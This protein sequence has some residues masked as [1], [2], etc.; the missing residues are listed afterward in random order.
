MT[1]DI[2]LRSYAGDIAW[3]PWALRS[4]HRFVTGIRD[5]VISVPREDIAA[6]K[7]LNLTKERLFPSIVETSEMEPYLGQ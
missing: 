1:T 7:S 6:F 4:I 2:F 3:V 5:I